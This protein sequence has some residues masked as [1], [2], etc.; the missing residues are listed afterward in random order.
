MLGLRT[1]AINHQLVTLL[2][3]LK[4]W[5]YCS[6]IM[7]NYGKKGDL[8][9]LWPALNFMPLTWKQDLSGWPENKGNGSAVCTWCSWPLRRKAFPET[10]SLPHLSSVVSHPLWAPCTGPFDWVWFWGLK[11]TLTPS[12]CPLFFLLLFGFSQTPFLL[13]YFFS[14]KFFIQLIFS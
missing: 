3:G 11:S 8:E 2:W 13:Q 6:T 1:L 5:L 14:S 9:I 12:I 4:S 7:R 10:V